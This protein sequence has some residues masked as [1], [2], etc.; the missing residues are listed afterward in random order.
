MVELLL[1]TAAVESSFGNHTG[2]ENRDDLGIFQM[3]IHT[4]QDIHKN[5]LKYQPALLRQTLMF[6]NSKR[7]ERWNLFHN[8]EYQ[9]IMAAI[10]Y[11]RFLQG[12]MPDPKKPWQM[13]IVWKLFFNTRLG[14]G[15]TVNFYRKYKHY[16]IDK[17]NDI[18]VLCRKT[19]KYK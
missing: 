9:I 15:T 6:R 1:G 12:R 8:L 13:A 11:Q 2:G 10:H 3:N 17:N 16:C 18:K 7:T 4:A 14:R 19:I 5:Y